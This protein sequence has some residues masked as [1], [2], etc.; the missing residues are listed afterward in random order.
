MKLSEIDLTPDIQLSLSNMDLTC[1]T[2]V[3]RAVLPVA[4]SGKDVIVAADTGSG[5][6]LAYLLPLF[7]RLLHR[8]ESSPAPGGAGPNALI[9]VPTRELAQQVMANASKL[10][11]HTTIGMAVISGGKGYEQQMAALNSGVDILVATPG[12]LVE[13]INQE[14][15]TLSNC[16]MLV[17]DEA[18]RMLDM[19]FR[20]ELNAIRR[21]LPETMQTMLFS[22]TL[23]EQVFKYSKK[24][25]NEPVK[26]ELKVRNTTVADV[27]QKVYLVDSDRKFELLRHLLQHQSW[28]QVLVFVRSR[29]D[30]DKL[31]SRLEVAGNPVAVLHGDKSQSERESIT[32]QFKRSDLRVLIA[33]DIA[34]R[35]LHIEK[36]PCVINYQLP[37]VPAEYVHRVGR[38]GRAGH[39]GLAISL[40][41]E[42]DTKHL[43]ALEAE[44]DQRLLQQWYP[45]F[46][47]DLTREQKLLSPAKSR[48]RKPKGR[49]RGTSRGRG[50]LT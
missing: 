19:G 31:A 39:L 10:V 35:G 18:D 49:S 43:A 15:C 8:Q 7:Q 38:T 3:Q 26:I 25:Q 20:K 16:L 48:Q 5:K 50:K 17:L 28:Q 32:Q 24:H 11:T 21:T 23:N 34:A 41:T 14:P 46:E 2:E 29:N 47:P 44:I 30:A 27:E 36:L 12:R 1:A 9:L 13:L 45:G 33:T 4:L 42:Q 37:F 40:V 22:A 6:T